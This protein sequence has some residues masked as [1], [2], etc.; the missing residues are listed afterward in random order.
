MAKKPPKQTTISQ[1]D[2]LTAA[3]ESLINRNNGRIGPRTLLEDARDPNSPFHSKFE[4]DDEVAGEQYRLAQASHFLREW[5]GVVMRVSSESKSIVVEVGRAL[6]SPASDRSKGGRSYQSIETI[7]ADPVKRD[8]LILTVL[9]ELRAY[10][11][12]Y[13]Q[14]IELANVWHEIDA[15]IHKHEPVGSMNKSVSDQVEVT[16]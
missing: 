11:K 7:M 1:H 16:T 8:D 14:L 5:K 15:A 12:R 6:Q 2:I 10:R 3:L 4:W 9:N 13:A